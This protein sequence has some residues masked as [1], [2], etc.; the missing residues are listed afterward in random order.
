MTCTGVPTVA[1]PRVF[2]HAHAE[3]RCCT[4]AVQPYSPDGPIGTQLQAKFAK[5]T[6]WPDALEARFPDV[7]SRLYWRM[8]RPGN[9]AEQPMA[10]R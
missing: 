8:S 3:D 4:A 10:T 9:H 7:D 6:I 2:T 1:K 5:R